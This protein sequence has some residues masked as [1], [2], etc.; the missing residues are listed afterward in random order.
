MLIKGKVSFQKL[1]IG[2]WGIIS[3]DGA[4]F[5]PLKL[6]KKYQKEGLDIAVEAEEMEGQMSGFMWGKIIQ[7]KKVY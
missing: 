5:Q 1:G 2:F 4:K 6:A 7:I 3:E